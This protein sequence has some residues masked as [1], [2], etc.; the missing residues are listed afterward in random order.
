M[1][2]SRIYLLGVDADHRGHVYEAPGTT[3]ND[4]LRGD[5]PWVAR[6]AR[7]TLLTTGVELINATPGG[8]LDSIPRETL[9]HALSH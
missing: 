8:K 7:D 3:D 5:M 1:G 9:E 4:P 2:F 6:R